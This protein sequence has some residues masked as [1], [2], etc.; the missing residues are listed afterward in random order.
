MKSA[1]ISVRET[2][3]FERK[4]NEL[5]ISSKKRRILEIC[6]EVQMNLIRVSKPEL[7][8]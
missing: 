6:I 7:T 5:E 8:R 1:V 3:I 4:I 2:G